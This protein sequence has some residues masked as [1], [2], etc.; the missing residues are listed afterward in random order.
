MTIRYSRRAL[1]HEVSHLQNQKGAGGSSVSRV[2][3]LRAGQPGFNFFHFITAT[4]LALGPTQ[5]PIQWLLGVL[6]PG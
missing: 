6:F 4:R 3:R 1:F 5:R 2:T